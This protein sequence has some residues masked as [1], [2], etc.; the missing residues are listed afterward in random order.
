VIGTVCDPHGD[1]KTTFP[2]LF[3]KPTVKL[4]VL[5]P[6]TILDKGDT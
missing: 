6:E 5:V 4:T 3:F 1:E 2:L